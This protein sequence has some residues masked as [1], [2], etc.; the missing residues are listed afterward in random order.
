MQTT[1]PLLDV[2][3]DFHVFREQRGFVGDRDWE[4]ARA[5]EWK[6]ST[7]LCC[8]NDQVTGGL[9]LVQVRYHAAAPPNLPQ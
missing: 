5:F 8:I 6:K 9:A 3:A 2:V 4:N 1:F 7:D